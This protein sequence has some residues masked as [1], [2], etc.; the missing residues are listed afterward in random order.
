MSADSTLKLS[1]LQ[2]RISG[3]AEMARKRK[4]KL[5][6]LRYEDKIKVIY[7]YLYP[8]KEERRNIPG[9]LAELIGVERTTM[10]RKLKAEVRIDDV[11]AQILC[12]YWNIDF[13]RF[14]VAETEQDIIN[15]LIRK[16]VKVSLSP[17]NVERFLK[18]VSDAFDKSKM[19]SEQ[20][21]FAG[22]LIEQLL[23][24]KRTFLKKPPNQ[25][26]PPNS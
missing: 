7:L 16:D 24:L 8:S 18:D 9:L 22:V 14:A 23:V 17:E 5:P 12:K 19:P 20:K 6:G 25:D 15:L 26:P 1:A 3:R 10:F 11:E 13:G 4:K 2:A 21:Q